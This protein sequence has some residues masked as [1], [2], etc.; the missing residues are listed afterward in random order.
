M[1]LPALL[2]CSL[3]LGCASTPPPPPEAA[4]RPEQAPPPAAAP[5]TPEARP[6]EP[7]PS[8][9]PP[10][11]QAGCL[12]NCAMV[13]GKCQSLVDPGPAFDGEGEE[14]EEIGPGPRPAEQMVKPCPPHCCRG[15]VD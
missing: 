2:A 10:E 9:P 13:H 14:T 12:P 11:V 15:Q 4:P 8:R 3:L 5:A 1:R 7:D 6:P